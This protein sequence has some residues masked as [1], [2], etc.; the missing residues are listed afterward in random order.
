M[1]D[2]ATPPAPRFPEGSRGRLLHALA[3]VLLQAASL[4][5]I[6]AV[7]LEAVAGG[8][9]AFIAGGPRSLLAVAVGMGVQIVGITILGLS[10]WGRMRPRDLGWHA[11]GLLA[12][13]GLGLVGAAGMV[14][15]LLAS[16]TLT[17]VA[18]PGEML[19]A[20]GAW[21]PLQRLTFAGIGLG[22][23]IAEETLFRGYLQPE[24]MRRLGPTLGIVLG[25][26][27]FSV[28]HV[29]FRPVSLLS[30]TLYGIL[31]GTMRGRDR[32]LVAPAVAHGVFW[33]VA[34]MV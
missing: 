15:L 19:D 3:L 7:V 9:D 18:T 16:V 11:D 22:A 4:V 5:L 13:I 6:Q 27:I 29:N 34:G 26:V 21:T 32:S 31:L 8:W 33:I 12:Q 20:M 1:N 23:A 30:K 24:L 2:P 25:A 17:G 10:V 14:A 28:Y